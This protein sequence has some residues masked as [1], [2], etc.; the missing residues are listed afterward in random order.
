MI[1]LGEFDGVHRGH[2]ALV[3]AARQLARQ[4][5]AVVV[6]VVADRG[7]GVPRIM[8][9]RR[10]CELLI[11]HGVSS[12]FVAPL[13]RPIDVR[14]ALGPALERT[15]P[16]AVFVDRESW[17]VQP[18]DALL[19]YVHG[20]GAEVRYR[21]AERD[22][23]LGTIDATSI[24]HR[25]RTGD[26]CAAGTL[27]GRPYELVGVIATR[28]TRCS[29]TGFKTERVLPA[30]DIV[31]PRNGVYAARTL[32]D[33]RWV[34]VAVNV[35]TRPTFDTSGRVVVDGH[36]IE[37]D[38]DLKDA[39]LSLRFVRRLRDEV[40]FSGPSDLAAQIELD[41]AAVSALLRSKA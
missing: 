21:A 36:L 20:I 12:T 5:D 2:V 10:R 11:S 35:G 1:L 23:T 34:G 9:V 8:G 26:V 31:L 25:I 24:I 22:T 16:I 33:R 18:H 40:Q 13:P 39:E 30:P 32:I 6:A 27:L 4:H 37:F 15:N 41:V 3:A 17:P 29:S 14:G 38:S 28:G 19:E 7:E